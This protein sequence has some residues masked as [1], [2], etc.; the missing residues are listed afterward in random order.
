[1]AEL[2][3]INPTEAQE[4]RLQVISKE[5][6]RLLEQEEM[7]W[8]QRSRVSWLKD[9]DKNTR[10]FHE[11]AKVRGYMVFMMRVEFGKRNMRILH[12][13]LN[14]IFNSFLKRKEVRT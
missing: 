5:L 3:L 6:E 2:N 13:S 9:G 10:F 4:D 1:M 8:R 11:R 7:M 12:W 14:N